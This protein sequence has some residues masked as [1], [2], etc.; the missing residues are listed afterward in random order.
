VSQERA[1]RGSAGQPGKDPGGGVSK[2]KL[3][4]LIELRLAGASLT[5]IAKDLGISTAPVCRSLQLPEVV[6]ALADAHRESRERVAKLLAASATEAI[7]G[8]LGIARG[9]AGDE[10]ASD[11]RAAWNDILTLSGV[12]PSALAAVGEA[13]SEA[14]TRDQLDELLARVAR[15]SPQLLQRHLEAAAR[16]QQIGPVEDTEAAG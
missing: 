10:R 5:E 2:A 16:E 13:P 8:L 4:R 14:P 7:R 9:E 12:T 11:R 1:R 3:P 6:A 15:Q